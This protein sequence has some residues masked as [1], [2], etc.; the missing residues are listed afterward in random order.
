MGTA[1]TPSPTTIQ[2]Y[3][4]SL[5]S[6]VMA[7]VQSDAFL[8]TI[9]GFVANTLPDKIPNLEN[10]EHSGSTKLSFFD[11]SYN[12]QLLECKGLKTL[13]ITEFIKLEDMVK[14][15]ASGDMIVSLGATL[16]I[17]GITC[18]GSANMDA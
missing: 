5:A 4:A 1:P 3:M 17:Q 15:D 2:Q 11:M 10:I 13:E 7:M 16:G 6:S 14:R 9:N 12:A 18:S 8:A